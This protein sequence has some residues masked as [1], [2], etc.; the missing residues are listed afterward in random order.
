MPFGAGPRACIGQHFSL[1]E[2]VATLAELV[3]DFDFTAP[4]G[5][6]D[7]VPVGS[8]VTLFPLEPVTAQVTPRP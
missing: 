3:R 4:A 1:L 6:S 5:S 2:S 8:G 7:Q